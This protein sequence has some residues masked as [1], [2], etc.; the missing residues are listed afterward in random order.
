MF[1]PIKAF[2]ERVAEVASKAEAIVKA[3]EQA[4]KTR[5]ITV[6]DDFIHSI[7]RSM[8][9]EGMALDQDCED[10]LAVLKTKLSDLKDTI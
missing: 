4:A 5:L 2:E 3:E 9:D 6:W 10:A 7:E 8:I 1:H